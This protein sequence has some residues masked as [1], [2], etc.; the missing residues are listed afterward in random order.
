MLI[1]IPTEIDEFGLIPTQSFPR[2]GKSGLPEC[3][4][5]LVGFTRRRATQEAE[6]S[7]KSL[8]DVSK[9]Q[10]YYIMNTIRNAMTCKYCDD[11]EMNRR[12][13][14]EGFGFNLDWLIANVCDCTRNEGD[15]V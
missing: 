12:Y 7:I 3:P 15:G 6:Y 4:T 10:I 13:R 1:M 11:N 2:S 9:N 14:E 8:I 5:L